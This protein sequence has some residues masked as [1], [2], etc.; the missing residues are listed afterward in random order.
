M[1]GDTVMLEEQDSAAP[2]I[3]AGWYT[4]P[5]E[6]SVVRWWSGEE[7]THHVQPRPLAVSVA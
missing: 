6:P 3:P 4:D 1:T 2:A 7:W 5:Q